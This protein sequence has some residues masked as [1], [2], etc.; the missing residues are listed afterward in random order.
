MIQKNHPERVNIRRKSAHER[1]L[2]LDSPTREQEKEIRVLE[3]RITGS[4]LHVRTYNK[5]SST[6]KPGN[7]SSQGNRPRRT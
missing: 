5:G 1:L 4:C 6:R 3:E 7:Q 2:A